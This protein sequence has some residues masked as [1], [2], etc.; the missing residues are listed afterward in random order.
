VTPGLELVIT[1]KGSAVIQD[2]IRLLEI[3]QFREDR[4]NGSVAERVKASFL[5]DRV[6][7]IA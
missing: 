5:G 6:I 1:D 2:Y 7:T 3:T 4:L